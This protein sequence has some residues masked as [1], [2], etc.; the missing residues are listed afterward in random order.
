M[1][2][3]VLA[4]G[5]LAALPSLGFAD[6][7]FIVE[8]VS[9]TQTSDGIPGAPSFFSFQ[10]GYDASLDYSGITVTSPGTASPVALQNLG[11]KTWEG[12]DSSYKSASSFNAAYPNG[13]YIFTQTGSIA[14]GIS[15]VNLTGGF[16]VE[17]V[18]TGSSLTNLTTIRPDSPI[19]V[20]FNGLSADEIASST[21]TL[22]VSNTPNPLGGFVYHLNSTATQFTFAPD[23]FIPGDHYTM[24]LLYEGPGL[25]ASRVNITT[26]TFT[27]A[28]PEP[29][30]F[31]Y[32][33][34]GFITLVFMSARSFRDKVTG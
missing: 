25:E 31:F 20:T 23:T 7:P 26:V 17:P 28:V 33:A 32:F 14:P 1:K 13:Q 11:G 29:A 2:P 5:I 6:N 8:V 30:D 27:A 3:F 9:Y 10:A 19:T 15:V 24:D 21:I 16:P 12:I 18:F 22:E 34:S 4:I